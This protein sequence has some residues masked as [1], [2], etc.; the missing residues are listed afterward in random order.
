[1]KFTWKAKLDSKN[2]LIIPLATRRS[3]DITPSQ[4]IEIVKKDKKLIIL[5][6][7]EQTDKE[8]RNIS[9]NLKKHVD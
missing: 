9:R 2:R 8:F 3:P 5:N 4:E 6:P 1:M 7:E